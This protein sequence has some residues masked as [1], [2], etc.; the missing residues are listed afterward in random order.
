MPREA[1]KR[2]YGERL[3]VRVCG[4]CFSEEALLLVRHKGL[5]DKGYFFSPPGGGMEFGESAENCLIREFYE[6]TGLNVKI[7]KFLFTHEFLSPP[8]HA[9]ELFFA[10]EDIGGALKTGF[11]PEMSIQ[12]QIIEEVKYMSPS[13]IKEEKGGQMHRMLNQVEQPLELLNM[14]GYFKFDNKT[15][16]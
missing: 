14:Q 13:S 4:L 8:L 7:K 6:E 9:I 3:R 2:I 11:D 12:E 16:K 5:T 1:I 10:V 15:L